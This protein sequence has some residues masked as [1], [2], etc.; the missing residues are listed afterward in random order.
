MSG[1][2][3]IGS[4]RPLPG[5]AVCRVLKPVSETKT[6]LVMVRP[7]AGMEG[8][9]VSEAVAEVIRVAPKL[10]S[11]GEAIHPGFEEG[12]KILIRDF[13]KYANQ[14]GN[15]VGEDRDDRAFLL[16]YRDVLAV[17]SGPGTIGLYDEY[18]LE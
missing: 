10:A 7:G 1:K 11:S 14:I 9:K 13:L 16:D 2:Y 18:V 6:G 5:W 3:D 4:V 17:V 12:D 15:L 8:G